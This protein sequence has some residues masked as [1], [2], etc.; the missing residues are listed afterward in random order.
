MTSSVRYGKILHS[1][2]RE[3]V[4]TVSWRPG[5][6]L[7]KCACPGILWKWRLDKLTWEVME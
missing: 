2:C 7:G 3:P 4:R 5:G 6:S 1:T